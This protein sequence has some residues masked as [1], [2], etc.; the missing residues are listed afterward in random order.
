MPQ[1]DEFLADLVEA[2]EEV[3][4]FERFL[5]LVVNH[6]LY[7]ILEEILDSQMI[8]VKVFSG[9]M[10]IHAVELG[11]KRL[12][13]L[14]LR[15]RCVLDA[16]RMLPFNKADC[17]NRA[18]ALDVAVL[19][20]RNPEI[21]RLLTDAG[22]DPSVHLVGFLPERIVHRW[23]VNSSMPSETESS[24]IRCLFDGF[25]DKDHDTSPSMV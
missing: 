10:L 8:A 3:D 22:A 24:V 5:L 11:D 18:T 25:A 9:K 4:P 1:D 21:V 14:L 19:F 13:S 2:L 23:S 7:W 12:I 16:Q 20:N 17:G 15:K 6:E